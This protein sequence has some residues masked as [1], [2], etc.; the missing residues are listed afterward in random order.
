MALQ[1]KKVHNR[2]MANT[3]TRLAAPAP[4]TPMTNIAASLCDQIATLAA[5]LRDGLDGSS[6]GDATRASFPSTI[7]PT[8]DLS[9]VMR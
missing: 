1:H 7:R 9:D 4:M 3:P 2:G 8:C 6:D 5:L